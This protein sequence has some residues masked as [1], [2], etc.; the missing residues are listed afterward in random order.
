M[1]TVQLQERMRVEGYGQRTIDA[2]TQCINTISKQVNKELTRITENDFIHFLDILVKR[3]NSPYTLNQYHAALKYLITK[4]YGHK[5]DI[6]LPYAKRHKRLP[7]TLSHEEISQ[8][9]EKTKNAKHRLML[10]LA[11][12]SGL[13]ISELVGLKVEN[14][15]FSTKQIMISQGKGKKDRHTIL[16]EKLINQLRNLIAGKNNEDYLFESERGGRLTTRSIQAVFTKALR[17]A[18]IVKKATFHSLRHSFATHLLEDGVD[19]KIIQEL[20]GHSN[21][22]T[23][24]VYT[25]VTNIGY[26]RS[27]L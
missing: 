22:A 14:L 19:I 27:P 23:T 11:Y 2:Y 12:G 24:L 5:W 17:A 20:L 1:I 9:I 6:K 3:G 13:R 18:G 8:L 10:S 16:P 21:I 15:D 4:V 26:I 7:I 25:H